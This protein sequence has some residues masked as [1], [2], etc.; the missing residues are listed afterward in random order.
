MKAFQTV[1]PKTRNLPFV[2]NYRDRVGG[3]CFAL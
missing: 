1:A 3:L 2:P